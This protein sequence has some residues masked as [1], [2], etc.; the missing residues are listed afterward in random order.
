MAASLC[1]V[2]FLVFG[3]VHAGDFDRSKLGHVAGWEI[4]RLC[5]GE[6][7]VW[8]YAIEFQ[9]QAIDSGWEGRALFDAFIHRLSEQVKDEL[10]TRELP[11]DL[12]RLISLAIRIDSR[13]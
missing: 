4:L 6:G 8:D 13:L 1:S 12:D 3:S 9:T 10:L 5:Q 7:S 2:G 11:E